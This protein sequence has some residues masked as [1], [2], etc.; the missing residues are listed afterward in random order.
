MSE[1]SQADQL[2]LFQYLSGADETSTAA[3]SLSS[4]G[5]LSQG[6]SP[7]PSSL[8]ESGDDPC[9]EDGAHIISGQT[10]VDKPVSDTLPKHEYLGGASSCASVPAF[11][12][13]SLSIQ[14]IKEVGAIMADSEDPTDLIASSIEALPALQPLVNSGPPQSLSEEQ[15]R[16]FHLEQALDQ[17]LHYLEELNARVKHQAIL[18]E[19]VTLTEEY[20]YVQYQAIARL[21][22]D[23]AE[24]KAIID[25]CNLNIASLESDRELAQTNLLSLQ[26]DQLSLRQENAQW[27]NAC[28]ELQQECDRQHRKMLALE[29]EKAVMQEQIL[30]QAR[31][32]NEHETAV[33]YW[34]DRYTSIQHNLQECQVL[35]EE[36]IRGM[37]DG[38]EDRDLA[39]L[40]TRIQL[41]GQDDSESAPADSLSEPSL[42]S[43]SIPEFL[44]RRYRH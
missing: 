44:I 16:I 6:F 35:L 14:E 19:Q 28:Q 42:P 43:F 17:A 1:L 21:Q 7:T 22:E 13:S 9:A 27:K 18:E 5:N 32:S 37:N 29:Q 40:L 31:Q 23:L 12:A 24:D 25:Q 38:N 39:N 36:K 2:C 4:Q 8:E 41:L 3:D 11:H 15:E 34:K 10:A 30:Q 33:Q 26:Q 20:A